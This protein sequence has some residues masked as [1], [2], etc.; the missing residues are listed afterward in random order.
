M[1]TSKYGMTISFIDLNMALYNTQQ[2]KVIIQKHG[3]DTITEYAVIC[4]ILALVVYFFMDAIPFEIRI[5]ICV[6]L[7][8]GFPIVFYFLKKVEV[9]FDNG[10]QAVFIVYPVIGQYELIRF[11]EID[12]VGFVTKSNNFSA[13]NAIGGYY[14]IAKKSDPMGKGIKVLTNV[15]LQNADAIDFNLYALPLLNKY[16][17][18][19]NATE[20]PFVNSVESLSYITVKEAGV[21]V[22]RSF[23]WFANLLW[24]CVLGLGIYITIGYIKDGIHEWAEGAAILVTV[25]MPLLVLFRSTRFITVDKNTNTVVSQFIGGL[26]M[27]ERTLNKFAGF[28][29][30][31]NSHNG[32]YTGTDLTMTF[33]DEAALSMTNYY[34]TTKLNTAVKEL[35]LVIYGKV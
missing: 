7:L 15:P 23:R 27:K 31:R 13:G 28:H 29:Y 14:Q 16:V 9:I 22:F 6:A 8:A 12:H 33:N 25:V 20:V 30:E 17:N 1:V 3:F 5:A 19:N 35:N 10:E 4:G 11:S 21:F 18:S 32:I 24:L 2:D 26:F 34:S